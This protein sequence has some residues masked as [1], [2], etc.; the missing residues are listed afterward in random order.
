MHLKL[1]TKASR[2]FK[3]PY[4]LGI[5]FVYLQSQLFLTKEKKQKLKKLLKEVLKSLKTLYIQP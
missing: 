4:L 2:K 3:V 1:L 5:N